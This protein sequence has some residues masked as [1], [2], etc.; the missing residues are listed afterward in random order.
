MVEITTIKE[1]ET[2]AIKKGEKKEKIKEID[3]RILRVMQ[4]EDLCVPQVTRI[5]HRVH[6]PTSTVHDRLTYLKK[7]G[8]IKSYSPI[9]DPKKLG[10]QVLV[11]V[12]ANLE[13]LEHPEIACEA[14]SK[15][16]FVQ[17]VYFLIGKDDILIK[18]RAKDIDEYMENMKK[19]R[20]YIVGGGGIVVSKVFKDTQKFPI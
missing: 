17:G 6:Q 13:N 10:K 12:L 11:F 19:L 2:T 1:R 15:F 9:L 7:I 3:I 20:K 16:P 14:V 18:V 5:A 8:V 4:E